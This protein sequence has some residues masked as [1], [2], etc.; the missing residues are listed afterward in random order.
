MAKANN[1]Y[2]IMANKYR[3]VILINNEKCQWNGEKT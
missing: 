2:V 3:I 1:K